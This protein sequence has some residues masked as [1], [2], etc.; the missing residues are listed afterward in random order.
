VEEIRLTPGEKLTVASLSDVGCVRKN[1][2]D[3]KGVF[4]GEDPARGHLFVVADGMGGAA[5]GEVASGIAVETVRGS[6]FDPASGRGPGDALRIAIEAAN[7]S[8]HRRAADDPRLGGMGTT[9][10][11][12]AV[13]GRSLWCGHVG[14]T[15][16]YVAANGSLTQITRDHSLAAELARAGNEAGAPPRAKNVL[17]RC[18]G[19]KPEVKVDVSEQG[20]PLPEDGVLVM[21]TDGLS[22]L[23]EDGEILHV[24]SMHLPDGACRRLIQLAKERG[25][26]DNITVIVARL[27]R[28]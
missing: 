18:L 11:A 1:N 21:C 28:G 6:Y 12:V 2:E 24:V 19:V 3:S 5:A 7:A 14:D 4:E 13:V 25:G 23:V 22:N 8:I 17:T 27:T 15:R 20:I 26:P 10:T 9:C 16:A